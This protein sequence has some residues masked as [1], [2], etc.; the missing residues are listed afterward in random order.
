MAVSSISRNLRDGN[1]VV[2]DGDSPA[3][4]I[5]ISLD[6]G[7]LRWTVRQQTIEVVDRGQLAQTRPGDEQP[8]DVEFTAGWTQ[9]ADLSTGGATALQ[10][11]E[12]LTFAA[13]AGVVST[14]PAGQQNTL[15]IVFTVTDPAGGASETITFAKF[16]HRFVEPREGDRRN[17]IR[18]VGRA[19]I[20]APAVAR[21]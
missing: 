3:N 5:S 17:V 8:V 10:L 4:S 6:S 20:T 1:I 14:S 7:D 21:I 19:F 11:Y 13:G 15:T 9:L 2:S 18:V 16:Y 12:M